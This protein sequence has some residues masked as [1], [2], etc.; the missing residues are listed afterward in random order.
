MTDRKYKTKDGFVIFHPTEGTHWAAPIIEDSDDF[1]E[2]QAPNLLP[3][4]II[5]RYEKCA[6]SANE[7]QDG[8]QL[9]RYFLFICYMYNQ[10]TYNKSH[11]CR[12]RFTI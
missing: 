1:S 2:Y 8:K 10:K 3:D 12:I 11:F 5:K 7:I 6:F 4:N 9:L